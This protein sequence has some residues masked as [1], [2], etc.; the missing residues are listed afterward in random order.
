MNC[1]GYECMN[2]NVDIQ[3]LKFYSRGTLELEMYFARCYMMLHKESPLRKKSKLLSVYR[4]GLAICIEMVGL[5][6]LWCHLGHN[7]ILSANG[8]PSPNLPPNGAVACA[9]AWRQE[10]HH[11]PSPHQFHHLSTQDS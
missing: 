9:N 8:L 2:V 6:W 10:F 4:I 1:I 5:V 11:H 7:A 3:A